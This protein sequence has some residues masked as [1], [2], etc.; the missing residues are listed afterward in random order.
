MKRIGF[1]L[2]AIGVA[3]SCCA[4]RAQSEPTGLEGAKWIW[5]SPGPNGSLSSLPAAV[6]YFRAEVDVPESPALESA[7]VII[8]CDN[9]FV[10]Y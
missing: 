10:L 8:T 5:S 2:L 3:A 6:S 4:P 9:L 1:A 7:E